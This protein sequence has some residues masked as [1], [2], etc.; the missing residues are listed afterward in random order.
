M[1]GSRFRVLRGPRRPRP[2]HPAS[3]VGRHDHDPEIRA[4]PHAHPRHHHRPP[5]AHPRRGLGATRGPRSTR[6]VALL[7]RRRAPPTAHRRRARTPLLA[8]ARPRPGTRRRTAPPGPQRRH[9]PR[10]PRRHPPS[11]SPPGPPR[12]SHHPPRAGADASPVDGRPRGRRLVVASLT[13]P[14]SY[15]ASPARY[16][17]SVSGRS[18]CRAG[19]SRATPAAT[20]CGRRGGPSATGPASC[21]RPWHRGGRP[22]RG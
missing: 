19:S 5:L 15:A 3:G 18:G 20:S 22:P 10:R 11:P 14:G 8:P 7:P 6:A 1:I 12:R 17:A 21:G 16:R 4:V 2:A 13:G 9:V